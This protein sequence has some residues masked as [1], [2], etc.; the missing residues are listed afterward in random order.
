[1]QAWGLI[2]LL[3]SK[4]AGHSA[5][6]PDMEQDK[7]A[8]VLH[9]QRAL[10]EVTEMIRT[11]HLVHKGLVNLQPP[12][13]V[14][15]SGDMMFGN[16]IALLSGDYL[17][18]NSS[19]E[20]ANLRNQELV[21]LM[22]SAVRDLTE[23]EFVGPRD[24]Q[25]NPLPAKPKAKQVEYKQ[26]IENNLEPLIVSE[27]LGNAQA[28]WTLRNVLNAGSLLGKSCQGTLKLAGHSEDLQEKGY[29]FGKHL[30]L[31]WQACLDR[32]PFQPGSSGSFSLVC[33]PLMF[34]LQNKPELYE[35]IEKGLENVD[36]VDYDLLRAEVLEGPGLELTKK[37][38]KEHSQAALKVLNELP[39]SDARTALANIIAAVQES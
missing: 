36:E 16:K 34:T 9:S 4:A 37:L 11:S 22:S 8:G 29:L 10:A 15:A 39:A 17:L 7:A 6:I 26:F 12:N 27:A 21:E 23:A 20:L 18:S 33:A 3:I 5:D 38:Q 1:M 32:E 31:A 13:N 24:R 30:A 25:N 14:D 28:E 19:I 35:H 2:V